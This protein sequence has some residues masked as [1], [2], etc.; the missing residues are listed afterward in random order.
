MSVFDGLIHFSYNVRLS[1]H[2]EKGN[3]FLNQFKLI[4]KL[5]LVLFVPRLGK[6]K[7]APVTF[8]LEDWV[9]D[10]SR[11]A[12]PNKNEKDNNR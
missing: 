6:R 9:V 10:C 11:K 5:N 8:F 3:V 4:I 1:T 2:T 12:T 7:I